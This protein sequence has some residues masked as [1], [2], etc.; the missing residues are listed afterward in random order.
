MGGERRHW[1]DVPCAVRDMHIKPLSTRS[2]SAQNY[3]RQMSLADQKM[4]FVPELPCRGPTNTEPGAVATGF[5][6]AQIQIRSSRGSVHRN[7]NPVATGSVL[8]DPPCKNSGSTI[9]CLCSDPKL[10]WL[11]RGIHPRSR[12]ASFRFVH[13]PASQVKAALSQ[14]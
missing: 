8:L 9:A 12:R 3:S 1:R 13:Y 14:P 2:S 6:L 4:L 5:N 11:S 10:I 7:L